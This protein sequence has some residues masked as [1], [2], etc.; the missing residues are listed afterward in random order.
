[1]NILKN[2]IGLTIFGVLLISVI[3]AFLIPFLVQDEELKKSFINGS[4]TLIFGVILSGV[5]KLLLDDLDRSRQKRGEQ[6]QFIRN[7]LD[8]LKSVYDGV[9]RT[10]ILVAAHQSAKTYGEEMHKLI[11]AQVKLRNVKRALDYET[12]GIE[13]SQSLETITSSVSSMETYL[14]KLTDEFQSQY[15][16]I[17]DAQRAY[18]FQISAQ[19]KQEGIDAKSPEKGFHNQA[20]QQ[21]ASLTQL[22]D[23]IKPFSETAKCDS[24]KPESRYKCKFLDPLDCASEQLRKELRRTLGK[25]STSDTVRQSP[26]Q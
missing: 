18:E 7:V 24:P 13:D 4:V 8:D 11:E 16:P 15:K 9:E 5:I 22:E 2:K 3:F 6:A 20:W 19:L 14:Q 23:F 1:M 17:A 25:V 26:Q 12:A 21:L 10:R